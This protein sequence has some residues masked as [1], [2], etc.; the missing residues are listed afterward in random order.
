VF[1]AMN[2]HKSHA[3]N[4]MSC[5]TGMITKRWNMDACSLRRIKQAGSIIYFDEP[6]IY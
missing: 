5:Q 3:A 6:S 1:F 4:G 2:L